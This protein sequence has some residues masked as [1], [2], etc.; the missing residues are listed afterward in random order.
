M[1]D[2]LSA[3]AAGDR[4]AIITRSEVV[5]FSAAGHIESPRVLVA[6][7]EVASI[8]AIYAALKAVVQA[9]SLTLVGLRVGSYLLVGCFLL[10]VA[11]WYRATAEPE[12]EPPRADWPVAP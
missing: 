6:Q 3:V 10:A 8:L 5:P 11:Y 2:S 4:P 9:S 7:P 12:V 1:S